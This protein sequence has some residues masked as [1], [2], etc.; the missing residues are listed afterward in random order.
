MSLCDKIFAKH[1][2][3]LIVTSGGYPYNATCP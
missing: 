2:N 3:A 1:A